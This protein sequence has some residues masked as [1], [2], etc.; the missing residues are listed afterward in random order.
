MK[1]VTQETVLARLTEEPVS[2]T[3]LVF[4]FILDEERQYQRLERTLE[5]LVM[6]RKIEVIKDVSIL[7]IAFGGE[8]LKGGSMFRYYKFRKNSTVPI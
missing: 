3:A 2:W 1:P 6:Q 5:K 4:H 7:D 8:H